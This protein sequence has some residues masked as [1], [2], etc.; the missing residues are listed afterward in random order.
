MKRTA[1]KSLAIISAVLSTIGIMIGVALVSLFNLMKSDPQFQIEFEQGILSDPT[2]GPEDLE[3]F[4][5]LFDFFGGAMW[6]II[7]GLIISLV[8][9]IIG[10]VNIWNSKNPKLAGTM[11]IISGVLAGFVSLPSIL[12]YIAGILCFV[13]KPTEIDKTAFTENQYDGTMRPL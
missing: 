10:L 13:R 6:F 5:M 1:E 2:L 7:I 4:N 11:F 8:L 3:V 9:T 12:L